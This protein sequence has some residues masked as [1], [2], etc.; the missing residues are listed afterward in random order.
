MKT[1]LLGNGMRQII[2]GFTLW[3]PSVVTHLQQPVIS[4]ANLK[5]Y[6][7]PHYTVES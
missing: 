1:Y 7:N 3:L 5:F 2:G 6:E 4:S